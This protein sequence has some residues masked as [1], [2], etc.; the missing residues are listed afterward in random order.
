MEALELFGYA[1]LDVQLEGVGAG[2]V[3]LCDVL[4]P[5]IASHVCHAGNARGTSM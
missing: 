2:G 1:G 5:D 4:V 3:G